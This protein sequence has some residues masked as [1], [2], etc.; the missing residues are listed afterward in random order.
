MLKSL[1]NLLLNEKFI[2]IIIVL[3]SVLIF[4][5]ESGVNSAAISV[6]DVCC[7]LI[8][9]VEM[10]VKIREW[11]FKGYWASGWNRLDGIL[12]LLSIPSLI[13]YFL[14][15]D[16]MDLSILLVLRMLRV[17]RFFRLIH[18]F[19]GF[20]QLLKNFGLAMRRSYAV[21]VGM[22]IIIIII[23]IIGCGLFKDVAPEYFAT[24]LDAIYTTFRIFTGEGWNEI[25][26]TVAGAMGGG[27]AHLIRLYFCL[28][29]VLGCIVGMSLLNSIFVDA[30]VSDNNDDVKD[31]LKSIEETLAEIK[32]KLK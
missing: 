23:A 6:M 5:Q 20:A 4:L 24:P 8:F 9:M 13:V 12:V 15:Y 25:P 10:V 16:T 21:F 26:D 27:A 29:L 3:S 32:D 1:K 7:S 18:A 17:F 19:P 22:I 28:V 11:G 30:M 2:L 14:P 31:Q